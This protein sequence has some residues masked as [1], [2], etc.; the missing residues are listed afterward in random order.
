[1]IKIV[2]NLFVKFYRN[3]HKKVMEAIN[4]LMENRGIKKQV[5]S[6]NDKSMIASY[7]SMNLYTRFPDLKLDFY[8]LMR[9]IQNVDMY[10][11]DLRHER[12]KSYYSYKEGAIYFERRLRF[13]DIK[14]LAV[15]ECLHFFQEVRDKR[16]I[17]YR[18]GIG[19]N[20]NEKLYGEELNNS[21]IELMTH[22]ACN[23]RTI[24]TNYCGII[25]NASMLTSNPLNYCLISQLA[26]L[27]GFKQLIDSTF[28]SKDDF[29]NEFKMKLGKSNV[30]RIEKG[31]DIISKEEKELA[32]AELEM[33]EYGYQE[34]K[35]QKK[36]NKIKNK[37][38]KDFFGTQNLIIKAYFDKKIKNILTIDDA[39][40]CRVQLYSFVNYIGKTDDYT[41]FNEY[42]VEKMIE[43]EQKF[44]ESNQNGLSVIKRN[45][46]SIIFNALKNI[47]KVKKRENVYIENK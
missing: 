6:E 40:H 8:T 18:F 45:R 36:I 13:D 14:K 24:K 7:V 12:I 47:Y 43:L 31:F 30:L 20:I 42:Y 5:I 23:E 9:S 38:K 26:N 2:Y 29:T 21:A 39:K 1:M 32:N 10:V 41:F 33:Q 11:T 25:V 28:Y 3:L 15:K 4:L 34:I 46:I 35:V 17:L 19:R 44:N 37:I 16:G 27:I 22:Y